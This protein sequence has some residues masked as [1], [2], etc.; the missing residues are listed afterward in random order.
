M[1]SLSPYLHFYASTGVD[2]ETFGSCYRGLNAKNGVLGPL[3]YTYIKDP[4]KKKYYKLFRLQNSTSNYSISIAP[5]LQLEPG[6]QFRA[7][8][9]M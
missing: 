8:A 3:S 4:T 6:L 5:I 1:Q 9:P 7:S 2:I